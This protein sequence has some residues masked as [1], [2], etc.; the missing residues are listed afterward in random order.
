ME[1]WT[2][3][4]KGGFETDGAFKNLLNWSARVVLVITAAMAFIGGTISVKYGL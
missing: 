2:T 1:M 3:S 4:V